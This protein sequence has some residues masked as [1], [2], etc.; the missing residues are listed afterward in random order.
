MV[1]Q[2]KLAVLFILV[3]SLLPTACDNKT[4]NNTSSNGTESTD[5][6]G[7]QI[8]TNKEHNNH[9]VVDN[10]GLKIMEDVRV[11]LTFNN[12]EVIVKMY[13]NPTSR[14]FLKNLPLTLTFE[15]YV[16]KE[17]ISFLSKR[18]T[19][20]DAPSG[21]AGDFAYYAPWGNLAIFY[22]GFGNAEGG[23]YVLGQIESGKEKL[24]DISDDFSVRIE[25]I[26]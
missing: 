9:S 1:K 25:K 26:D 20:E 14:E 18:L 2:F 16:G 7:D 23:L 10:G 6:T 21:D 17:K 24:E 13:D 11:K 4:E 12:E 3:T 15:D 5:S 19:V 8:V 22:K